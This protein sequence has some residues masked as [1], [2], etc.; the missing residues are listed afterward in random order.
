MPTISIF[1]GLYIRMYY[2]DH[3]PAH[4]HAYYSGAEAIYEIATLGVLA[5]GLPNRANALV[6][7][8]AV[9]HRGELSKNW[10]LA[11]AHQPLSPIR[12]LE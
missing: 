2:D 12:P 3:E 9:A 5:G 6:L 8:W 7:E 1:F 4:F 10:Q 11:Q